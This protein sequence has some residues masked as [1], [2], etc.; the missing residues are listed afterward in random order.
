[1]PDVPI[2]PARFDAYGG[3]GHVRVAG[4]NMAETRVG[5]TGYYCTYCGGFGV[6]ATTCD[7]PK[8]DP[9]VPGPPIPASGG[10]RDISTAPKD[11]TDV[12][13]TDGLYRRVGYWAKRI[14]CWSID[15]VGP[16]RAPTHWLP[17]PPLEAR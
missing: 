6:H 14:E 2:V 16:L 17:I 7:V 10:W 13:L 11:G 15:A 8:A 3:H 12:L 5:G 1:M 9:G 4:E